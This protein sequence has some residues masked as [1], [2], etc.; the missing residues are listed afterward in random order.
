VK[1]LACRR[2]AYCAGIPTLTNIIEAISGVTIN[3]LAARRA[4]QRQKIEN[5]HNK[6][7]P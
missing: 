5:P 7:R 6:S 1:G 4:F 3:L 2:F